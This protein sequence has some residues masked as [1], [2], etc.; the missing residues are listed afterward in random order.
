MTLNDSWQR[1]LTRERKRLADAEKTRADA[2]QKIARL[3]K[4]LANDKQR[5]RSG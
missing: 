5:G 2:L 4:K 1:Q 3:E